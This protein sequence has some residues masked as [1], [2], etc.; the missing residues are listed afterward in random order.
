MF[1]YKKGQSNLGYSVKKKS[2]LPFKV[3]IAQKRFFHHAG[4]RVR[5]HDCPWEQEQAQVRLLQPQDV[6][7]CAEELREGV[8]RLLPGGR[9]GQ[10]REWNIRTGMKWNW[11]YSY[12]I[13]SNIASGELGCFLYRLFHRDHMMCT[14]YVLVVGRIFESMYSARVTLWMAV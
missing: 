6:G 12:W 10:R 3:K 11:L 2:F 1:S 7:L 5:H 14:S 4:V 13:W 9:R 8:G